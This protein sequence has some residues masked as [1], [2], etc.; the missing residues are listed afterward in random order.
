LEVFDG[1]VRFSGEQ[2]SH[3]ISGH[4]LPGPAQLEDLPELQSREIPDEIPAQH[5]YNSSNFVCWPTSI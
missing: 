3:F 5:E 4:D 1:E 2:V